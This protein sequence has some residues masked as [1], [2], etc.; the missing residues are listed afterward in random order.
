MRE[1]RSLACPFV[2]HSIPFPQEYA[3]VK[4]ASQP[5][6][7]LRRTACPA[8]HGHVCVSFRKR[9][10]FPASH[11]HVA[12]FPIADPR[13]SQALSWRL[14]RSPGAAF[15]LL[16][17]ALLLAPSA[18]KTAVLPAL[19]SCQTPCPSLR[20]PSV[21]HGKPP[22]RGGSDRQNTPGELERAA[23]LLNNNRPRWREW[24]G[25]EDFCGRNP[26]DSSKNWRGWHGRGSLI[27]HPP[28]C[29]N[30][31]A[32][33][34]HASPPRTTPVSA[35]LCAGHGC[36]F[37]ETPFQ[38]RVFPALAAGSH[39]T[40]AQSA[41]AVAEELLPPPC[42]AKTGAPRLSGRAPRS[43]ILTARRAPVPPSG[44]RRPSGWSPCPAG[45][46]APSRRSARAGAPSR[47]LPARRPR[48]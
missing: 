10:P 2:R 29:H 26:Q 14:I 24:R 31:G 44:E 28:A 32:R 43:L 42:R 15:D 34:K 45:S 47:G 35:G 7:A 40:F 19:S 4:R 39:R 27:P 16:R 22:P 12:V 5:V 41:G 38:R 25:R 37:G 46:A 21:R 17:N 6:K 1:A 18:R 11:G 30:P 3:P 33:M 9:I 13:A 20:R 36:F 48:W 23:A 8:G